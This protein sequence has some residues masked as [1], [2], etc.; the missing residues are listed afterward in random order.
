MGGE[1]VKNTMI[2]QVLQMVAPHPCSGCAKLGTVLCNDCKYDIIH[3][4]FVGCFV[5]GLPENDG[6]CAQHRSP[7]QKAFIISTRTDALEDAIN[8][9]KF[10]NTK[11]AARSLAELL[12]W[13]L[14][15]IP[16]DVQIVPIPTVRSHIRKRGYDQVDLIARH[17]S[18]FRGNSIAR[19]LKRHGDATQHT[20]DR[21]TR[22]LQAAS[23]YTLKE[24]SHRTGQIL[25]LIDDITTTGSTLQAAAH[26]LAA[27]G[28]T[29]WVAVLAYQPLD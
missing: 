10:H 13:F 11:A 19:L 4:P 8:R 16:R 6:I 12:D 25:L 1:Y 15:V 26:V 2:Q 17:L 14:P 21:E 9:L 7:V 20:A 28:A 3:E 27:T 24:S 18:I 23:A 5:C 29:I 22:L